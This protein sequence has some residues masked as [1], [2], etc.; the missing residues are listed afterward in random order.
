MTDK[1]MRRLK[2]RELL[3]MLLMQC[4]ETERLTL[5]TEELHKQ[6]ETILESYERLK[7][8]LDVKDERLNQKDQKIAEL[9]AELEKQK[10]EREIEL[11][12]VGSIAGATKRLNVIFD[13]AQRAAEQYLS[14]VRKLE[15]R[16]RPF[17]QER[18]AGARGVQNT[19]SGRIVTMKSGQMTGNFERNKNLTEKMQT[20]YKAVAAVSGDIYV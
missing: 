6:M 19:R 9:K 4:E 8:K 16:Q 13:E 14:S 10:A 18:T 17:G 15:A 11:E 3:Q 20:D 12:E 5:E 1:E 7:K 2:R